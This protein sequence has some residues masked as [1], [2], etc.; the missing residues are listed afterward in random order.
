[1]VIFVFLKFGMTKLLETLQT[2]SNVYSMS[3]KRG[4]DGRLFMCSYVARLIVVPLVAV[5]ISAID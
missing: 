3:I 5:G 1:M 2:V 4:K